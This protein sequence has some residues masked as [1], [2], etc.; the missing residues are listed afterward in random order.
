LF[1]CLTLVALTAGCRRK[2][3]GIT[4]TT[5]ASTSPRD[6]SLSADDPQPVPLAACLPTPVSSSGAGNGSGILRVR[7]PSDPPH[8]DPL[9][10]VSD[11]A[12]LVLLGLVQEP[13]LTCRPNSDG[14]T[15][16]VQPASGPIAAWELAATADAFTLHIRPGGIFHDGR[17]LTSADVRAS[18][19]SVWK[20]AG[21]L[22]HVRAALVDLAGIETPS[23]DVVR[24]RLKRPSP[25]TLRALCDVPLVSA[26]VIYGPRR[27]VEGTTV[28]AGPIGTGPFRFAGWTKGKSIRLVRFA[29]PGR[30]LPALSEILFVIEPD[31]GRAL[32]RLRQGEIDVIPQLAPVHFPEQVRPAALGESSRL[33]VLRGQRHSFIAINHHRPPLDNVVFRRAL[34][35]LW[36]RAGLADELH[37]G[38]AQPIGAP[39]FA[40]IPPPAFDVAQAKKLLREAGVLSADGVQKRVPPITARVSLLHSGSRTAR[41][42][43]RRYV[44][45]LRRL[46]VFVELQPL[47][48]AALVDRIHTGE[49]DLALVSWQGPAAEDPRPRFASQGTFNYGKFHSVAVDNLLEEMR[50][51]DGPLSRAGLDQRLGQRLAEE[52]PAIFLYRHNDLAVAS[53]RVAGLCNQDGQVSLVGASVAP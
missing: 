27:R 44:E 41:A 26:G 10:E 38:L 16:I 21:R 39:P 42:E 3:P 6:A 48:H 49:F 2:S 40:T 35:L 50:V 43:L 32:G 30:P 20:G 7:L 12:G 11:V 23:P 28:D 53:R 25:I 46:G 8:L 34:S 51:G 31:T 29:Q 13:L 18:I 19:E 15:P 17:A 1:A 45:R 9:D 24:V 22:P 5:R 33:L 14:A 52:L 36:D 37:R 4:A 47:E